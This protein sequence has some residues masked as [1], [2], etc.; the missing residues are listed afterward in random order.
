[1]YGFDTVVL[2]VP[3][4]PSKEASIE[5]LK[6]GKKQ[7]VTPNQNTSLSALAILEEKNGGTVTVRMYHNDYA[8]PPLLAQLFRFRNTFQFKLSPYVFGQFQEWV[9]I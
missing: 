4:V 1:M 8:K 3:S 9:E 2:G 7:R 5:D 6:F